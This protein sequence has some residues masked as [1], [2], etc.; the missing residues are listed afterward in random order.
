MFCVLDRVK[1]AGDRVLFLLFGPTL[2]ETLDAHLFL[3]QELE[4]PALTITNAK[5]NKRIS[6]V[7]R[8]P[9]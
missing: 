3:V 4:L 2:S 5:R 1:K 7:P 6:R 8:H 9:H